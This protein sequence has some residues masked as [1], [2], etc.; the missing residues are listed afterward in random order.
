MLGAL[1]LK[2]HVPT[3]LKCN[4]PLVLRDSPASGDAAAPPHLVPSGEPEGFEAISRWLSAQARHHRT[5]SRSV[6]ILQGRPIARF[7]DWSPNG[8]PIRAW[9]DSVPNG[10][11]IPEAADSLPNGERITDSGNSAPSVFVTS[12]MNHK[13]R[14]EGRGHRDIR[15]L[16]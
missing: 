10:N 14:V 13:L 11:D 16:Y 8:R 15:S 12:P 5:A 4:S 3:G 1:H 9:P 7:E 6:S 2:N